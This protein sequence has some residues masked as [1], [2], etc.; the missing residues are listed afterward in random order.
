[1]TR[2]S[3]TADNGS[4][5]TPLTRLSGVISAGSIANASIFSSSRLPSIPLPY[6]RAS[7]IGAKFGMDRGTGYDVPQSQPIYRPVGSG[8]RSPK[9][10]FPGLKSFVSMF[11]LLLIAILVA[12]GQHFYYNYLNGRSVNNVPVSQSWIIRGGTAFAFLFKTCLTMAVGV[13]FC[14]SFWFLI[15]RT[16][17]EVGSLDAIFVLLQSPLS[18]FVG[19]LWVRAKLLLLVALIAWLVP[20]SAVL[21]PGALTGSTFAN[22]SD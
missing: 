16:T 14:Q 5:E 19:D 8:S 3:S 22:S 10:R 2:R 21:S 15:R 13:S 1:V 17:L 11:I 18:F 20:I 7:V 4:P 9:P 6:L 12:G